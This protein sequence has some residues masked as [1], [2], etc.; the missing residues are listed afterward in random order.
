MK[1]DIGCPESIEITRR[2]EPICTIEID[3]GEEHEPAKIT[4]INEGQAEISGWAPG[5]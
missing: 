1:I 2:G 4:I 5:L 3:P